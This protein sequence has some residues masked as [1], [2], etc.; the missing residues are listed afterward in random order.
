MSSCVSFGDR[1]RCGDRGRPDCPA[2]LAVSLLVLY[3]QRARLRLS[4]S[5]AGV[6]AC[7]ALESIGRILYIAA[8]VAFGAI[9]P[10]PARP[11]RAA[12]HDALLVHS[13]SS[14]RWEPSDADFVHAQ[15][16]SRHDR[17]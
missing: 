15:R 4:T 2:H 16:Q 7:N 9:T 10:V 14:I 8:S 1:H 12:S 3:P 13:L 5:S 6:P 11:L 17:R